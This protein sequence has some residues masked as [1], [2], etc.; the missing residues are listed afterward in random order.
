MHQYCM[1]KYVL[2]R[3]LQQSVLLTRSRKKKSGKEFNKPF[4]GF[5][6]PRLLLAHSA[7]VTMLT[8]LCLLVTKY[9]SGPSPAAPGPTALLCPSP[10]TFPDPYLLLFSRQ[11]VSVCE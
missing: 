7:N 1:D 4:I 9:I 6:Q 10:Q 2:S 8:F 11:V 5:W 3:G